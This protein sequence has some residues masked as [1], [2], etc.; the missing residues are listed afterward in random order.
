MSERMGFA[1][2]TY[3]TEKKKFVKITESL[4]IF[5]KLSS[6]SESDLIAPLFYQTFWHFFL[7]ALFV[8]FKKLLVKSLGFQ[9]WLRVTWQFINL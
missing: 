4:V 2:I 5:T 7:Y 3:H 1:S 6:N 8:K 9:V